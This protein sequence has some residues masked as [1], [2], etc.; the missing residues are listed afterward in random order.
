MRQLCTVLAAFAVFA[1]TALAQQDGPYKVLQTAQVG[2]E[3]GW[4]Y[5]FADSEGRDGGFTFRAAQV[6]LLLLPTQRLRCR[7]SGHD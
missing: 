6:T 1:P 7:R 2:G 4:D 3:G 5:I